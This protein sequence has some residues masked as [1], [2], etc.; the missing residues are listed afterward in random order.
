MLLTLALPSLPAGAA[1]PRSATG[2]GTSSRVAG[3]ALE[4]RGFGH[5]RGLSQYGAQGAARDGVGW[6]RILRFYYPGTGLGR[7]GGRLAVLLTADSEDRSDDVK[8]RARS[9]LS[10][11]S[12][13]KDRTWRLDR[14]DSRARLWRV[15]PDARGRSVI[16]RKRS[17]GGWRTWRRFPGEA[18]LFAKGG[19]VTL[20]TPAGRTAYRG[21]LRSTAVDARGTERDTVNVVPL[22]QYL[23]GVVPQEVPALWE[24]DAVRA[25][26]VAARTYA[27]FERDSTNRS[28]YDLCDTAAC[29]VYGGAS[30]EHP[31]SDAA[32]RAT[33]KRV[34]AEGGDP[35][36]AQFSASNGGYSVAGPFDYLPAREDPWDPFTWTRTISVSDLETAF[37]TLGDYEGIE[38]VERD[39]RGA[40][41]GRVVRVTVTGSEGSSTVSGDTFRIRLGLP[42]TLLREVP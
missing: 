11:R 40:F 26:A 15:V 16:Q 13:R 30:A 12:L 38:V 7:Q 36:F 3:V 34:V 41:G 20:V 29:Q 17:S 6:K 14:A 21:T 1:D 4:G 2:S 27:A 31:A 28:S 9:R 39:G 8:V 22:E 19:P 33:A 32:V 10:V 35:V 18:E 5:G 25:Q 42:S 37:D 23:R 24:P